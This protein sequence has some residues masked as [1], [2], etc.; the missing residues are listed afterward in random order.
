MLFVFQ[1]L[2]KKGENI[3][4]LLEMIL[5]VAEMLDLKA[6]P[7]RNAI[8]TIIEAKLDKGK[9]PM[10]SVLVQNGTLKVGDTVVSGIAFGRMR[11]MF[12]ENGKSMIKAGPSIPVSILGLDA[13]P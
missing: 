9:G 10:A 12:N 7:S 2:R 5:L 11:A 6:N 1:F 4:K 3:D 13:V 8:G